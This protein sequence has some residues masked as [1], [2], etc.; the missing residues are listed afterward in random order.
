MN[1]MEVV[2]ALCTAGADPHM[3]S[4]TPQSLKDKSFDQKKFEI[5]HGCASHFPV[6]FMRI[7]LVKETTYQQQYWSVKVGLGNPWFPR[8]DIIPPVASMKLQV[9]SECCIHST[10]W[11]IFSN[12]LVTGIDAAA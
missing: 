5:R 12:S 2:V 1:H 10:P 9:D 11:A 8:N 7:N 6:L 4:Q 3:G